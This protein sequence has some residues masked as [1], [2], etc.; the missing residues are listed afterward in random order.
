MILGNEDD[1]YAVRTLL[2]WGIVG[3]TNPDGRMA[4]DDG[5][6]NC[7]RIVT[8]EIGRAPTQESKFVINTQMKEIINAFMV[9]K[10]FEVDFSERNSSSQLI[11][12]EDRKFLKGAKEGIRHLEDGHPLKDMKAG[13]PNNRAMTLNHLMP[14]RRKLEL[15]DSYHKHYTAFMT[16]VIDNGYA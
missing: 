4:P 13:L 11:S 3:P 12:Q 5:V 15:N 8:N 6:S 7:H 2:G 10:I 9:N 1:P 14:L 16:K